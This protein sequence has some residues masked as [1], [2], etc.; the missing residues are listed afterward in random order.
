MLVITAL[1]SQV[2]ISLVAEMMLMNPFHTT[3]K[4]ERD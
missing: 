2:V 4:T 3:F 1:L